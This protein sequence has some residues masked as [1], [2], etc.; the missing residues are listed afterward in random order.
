MQHLGEG[1]SRLQVPADTSFAPDSPMRKPSGPRSISADSRSSQPK[2]ASQSRRVDKVPTALEQRYPRALAALLTKW[3]DRDTIRRPMASIFDGDPV[4]EMVTFLSVLQEE[5]TEIESDNASTILLLAACA[6]RE[7]G[8]SSLRLTRRNIFRLILAC[9]LSTVK[10]HWKAS[11]WTNRQF[12]TRVH[13]DSAEVDEL[14]RACLQL[15]SF[16]VR[17]TDPQYAEVA[18]ELLQLMSSIDC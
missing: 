12:G 17:I 2:R 3:I 11:A 7:I 1:V 8:Q 16:R 9:T 15:Y 18:R 10:V 13:L 5:I 6:V 4:T 14:E